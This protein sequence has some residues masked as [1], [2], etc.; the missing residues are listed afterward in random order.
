MTQPIVRF[1][2]K[3]QI[4]PSGCWEWSDRRNRDGYAT[5][6]NGE[7]FPGR[8]GKRGGPV[9]VLGHRWSYAHHVGPIP[10]GMKVLHSCDNPPCV[11][12]EHL[13]IGTQADNIRDCAAKGRRNQTRY[14]KL[15]AD[16]H[17]EIR[18]R[19]EYGVAQA[20]IS[21]IVGGRA[22]KRCDP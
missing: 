19:F 10:E 18:A 9:T 12:P 1:S 21:T 15:T 14:V 8:D 7:R 3:Y 17:T 4:T 20:T 16:Q 13:F 6:W 2:Q 11:N 22:R 5:F